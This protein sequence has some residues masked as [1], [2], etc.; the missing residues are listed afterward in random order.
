MEIY[1]NGASLRCSNKAFPRQTLTNSIGDDKGKKGSR[2]N[3]HGYFRFFLAISTDIHFAKK[4]LN[5]LEHVC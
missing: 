5:R 1:P 2:E 3:V 4:G